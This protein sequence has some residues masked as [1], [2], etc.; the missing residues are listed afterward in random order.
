MRLIWLVLLPYLL[1]G[2]ERIQPGTK[3]TLSREWKVSVVVVAVGTGMDIASSVGKPE[4]NPV[5]GAR[6]GGRDAVIRAGTVAGMVGFQYW[7]MRREDCPKWVKKWAP[8]V[9][10]VWGSAATAVAVRNWRKGV[11]R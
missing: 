8:R 5:W 11:K 2:Q 7:L 10:F 1:V 3:A 4:R 9:N 6:F